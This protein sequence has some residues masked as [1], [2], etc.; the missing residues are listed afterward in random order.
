MNIDK[1]I[2]EGT[3]ILKRNKINNPYLDSE[4]LIAEVLKKDREYIILNPNRNIKREKFESYINLIEQRSTGKPI[5]YL[6]KKKSFWNSE[7]EITDDVLIPRPDTEILI[8]ETLNIFRFKKHANILDIGVGSGCILL[9]ILKEKPYFY[10]TGIDLS[11]KAIELSRMNA[12]KLRLYNKVKLIKTNVDNFCFGK[13]DL[14]VSNPPYIKKSKIKY[15]EKDVSVFEPKLALDGGLDGTIK[16]FNI[17]KKASTLLKKN[18]KLV[19]EIAHNQKN[20][21]IK[22]LKQKGFYINKIKKDYALND[23][24]IIST[25]IR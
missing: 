19:L 7:F 4:I 2:I 14:I 5:A 6:T 11:V 16:I 8:E 24:C 1:A 12:K 23:R 3:K 13:Y 25:K 10:G 18:G 20:K 9:S 15:L 17:I 21:V 22:M